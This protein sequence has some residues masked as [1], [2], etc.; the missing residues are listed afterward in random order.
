[1]CIIVSNLLPFH[2]S[3]EYTKNWN[4]SL[5]NQKT[6]RPSEITLPKGF[7]KSSAE[8]TRLNI[9]IIK[10]VSAIKKVCTIIICLFIRLR[11]CR[12]SFQL[13]RLGK[14]MWII[15]RIIRITPAILMY[16]SMIQ[17]LAKLYILRNGVNFVDS[18]TFKP[19]DLKFSS[20][21]LGEWKCRNPILNAK[22]LTISL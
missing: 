21:V 11:A 18:A 16:I 19:A 12:S 6:A 7:V 15:P 3:F 5:M 13:K 10:T 2:S 22:K 14:A 4:T 17:L 20:H 8:Y 1:M 9:P